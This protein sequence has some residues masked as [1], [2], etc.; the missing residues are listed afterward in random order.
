[1]LV[2]M[3]SGHVWL[4]QKCAARRFSARTLYSTDHE[5]VRVEDGT[6]AVV[7]ITDYAQ[8]ALGDLVYVELPKEGA[9]VARA[10]LI[11]VVESVKGASDVYAPVSG[12]VV[13]VNREVARKP[14]LINRQP[15]GDGWLCKMRLQD[16]D[17]LAQLMTAE[18]YAEFCATKEQ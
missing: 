10:A 5:W 18:R 12:T 2:N 17:E 3:R 11:G 13:A 1:M 8:R 16:Q 4:L 9:V 15:M 6:H 7:G 14:S